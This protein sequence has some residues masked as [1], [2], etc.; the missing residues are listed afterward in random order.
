MR[1]AD[2]AALGALYESHLAT[3][4]ERVEAALDAAGRDALVIFAGAERTR[5]R[6]DI[7]YPYRPEPHFA[8]FVPLLEHPGS[9][10][11]LVPGRRPRIVC[12]QPDDFWHAPPADPDGF[13][14]GHFDIEVTRSAAATRAALTVPG[15]RTAVVGEP[16]GRDPREQHVDDTRVLAELD[17]RRAYKTDYETACLARA[18]E[19]A[20]RGHA[21]VAA[22]A[23]ETESEWELHERFLAATLQRESELPYPCIIALNEH[24]AVLH[25]QR[26]EAEPP[27]AFRTLLIDAGATCNGYAAD[28]T[29]THTAGDTRFGELAAAVD[30]LQQEIAADAVAGTDFVALDDLAHA[31]LARVLVEH[32]LVRCTPDAAYESGLT[33]VFLPHGLGHLLGLQVHDA[34]GRQVAPDGATRAPPERSPFLRLTRTLE[35]GFAVT[36]EPGLYFIPSL[37][38]GLEPGLAELVDWPR[39]RPL[40]R[41]GGIRVEDDIVVTSAGSENLTRNALR[42]A[43]P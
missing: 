7:A 18:N 6:D 16:D 2:D 4:L 30:A 33:R 35:P 12:E 32:G 13:W 19:I 8:A 21:A 31:R 23:G 40:M 25:Y 5:P 27:E 36:I 28:V 42:P 14:T 15:R 20:A 10:V 17:Y 41:Y 38:E 37:L 22:A 11:E 43:G 1:V 24:A 26:L 39:V 34:G 9:A 3:Q 29:R